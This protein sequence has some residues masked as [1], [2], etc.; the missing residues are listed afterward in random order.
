MEFCTNRAAFQERIER[1]ESG[2]QW[3][4]QNIKMSVPKSWQHE[5]LSSQRLK[6]QIPITPMLVAKLGVLATLVIILLV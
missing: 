5:S 6:R 2:E 3:G 1:I 4:A